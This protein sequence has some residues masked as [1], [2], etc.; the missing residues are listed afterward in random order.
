MQLL[1]ESAFIPDV[2]GRTFVPGATAVW[3]NPLC[4]NK[5]GLYQ[6]GRDREG[7]GS[8]APSEALQG[9]TDS[10]ISLE[11]SPVVRALCGSWAGDKICFYCVQILGGEYLIW[12]P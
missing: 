9:C 5:G 12:F 8:G 7:R 4:R 2:P 1:R 11:I 6:P 3:E 10:H